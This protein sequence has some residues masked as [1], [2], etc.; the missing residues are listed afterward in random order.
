MAQEAG[1]IVAARQEQPG[2]QTQ[3]R[4][5]HATVRPRPHH[6]GPPGAEAQRLPRPGHEQ[7]VDRQR[8][9]QEQ[10]PHLHAVD[11]EVHNFA[12]EGDQ[13]ER[14][15]K[16]DPADGH[17]FERKKEED[18]RP[19]QRRRAGR[20]EQPQRGL[21]MLIAGQQAERRRE[22][23]PER[24]G[25]GVQPFAR[26][27]DQPLPRG[28]IVTGPVGNPVILPDMPRKGG[29]PE[30]NQQRHSGQE[31]LRLSETGIGHI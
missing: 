29:E 27:I 24:G 20:P 15:P 23:H 25:K 7:A 5:I 6:P 16:R 31:Q 10:Q 18:Q 3:R 17:G 4:D 13:P 19:A 21:V 9:K 14:Q 2:P 22:Q 8:R 1:T 30:A 12:V 28:Q 26:R 11:A